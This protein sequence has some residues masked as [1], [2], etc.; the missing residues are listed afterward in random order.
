MVLHGF[1]R[2]IMVRGD[3]AAPT[4]TGA[5]EAPTTEANEA[6]RNLILFGDNLAA[7]SALGRNEPMRESIDLV[8][9]DPPYNTGTSWESAHFQEAYDDAWASD[10]DFYAFL[11]PRLAALPAL[12]SARGSLYV[13]IDVRINPYVRVMLDEILG[14]RCFRNQITRIKCNPKNFPR[15]AYG[16]VCDMV[17]FYSKSPAGSSPDPLLWNDHRLPW[18]QEDLARLY[19]K[20][21][22]NGRRYATTPLHAKGVT[23]DGPTGQPW[24]GI[25]P[26]AG[27]HWRRPPE[28]LEE[29]AQQGR[30]HWSEN[31]NPRE[32]IYADESLGRRPQDLWEFK[33]PGAKRGAYP[34]QKP[35]EML[36]MIV[37]QSSAP[38]SVVLDPFAGGGTTLVAAHRLGRR[39]I[40]LDQS[41][42]SLATLR[43]C[44]ALDEGAHFDLWLQD[45][46]SLHEPNGPSA[47]VEVL[48][49]DS[50]TGMEQ[51][52]VRRLRVSLPGRPIGDITFC[53]SL[54]GDPDQTAPA[55][56]TT[57]VVA[58]ALT[59]DEGT[60][61]LTPSESLPGA[62]ILVVGADGSRHVVQVPPPAFGQP[63]SV[64][65]P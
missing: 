56:G 48:V 9:A 32:I 28:V 22:A 51:R 1:Q 2:A 26:P 33:D 4:L 34:T 23:A 5:D 8:Y 31:G 54:T 3:V 35:V 17:C 11:R 43:R 52:G 20:V 58:R 64:L 14:A 44:L 25:S 42:L 55:G 45:G 37:A 46:V 53:A 49:P 10:E 16:S 19:P 63:R 36:E 12:L 38:E 65:A 15:R 27:K 18:T 29:W 59:L 6:P 30:I 57:L 13:H 39:F 60:L 47:A 61:P 40:G 50:N 24:R 41:P 62:F 7:L 21:D